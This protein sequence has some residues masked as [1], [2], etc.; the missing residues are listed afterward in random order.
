[1]IQ[2]VV[3][4]LWLTLFCNYSCSEYT[5]LLSLYQDK[6]CAMCEYPQ[7]KYYYINEIDKTCS[8]TCITKKQYS[9]FKYVF[10]GLKQ[11]NTTTLP[12]EKHGYHVDSATMEEGTCPLCST[13]DVYKKDYFSRIILKSDTQSTSNPCSI[14]YP[15]KN[16]QLSEFV[17]HTWYSQYQQEV[18]YQTIDSF[19]CV[20]ATYNI[21]K[22]RTV[23]FFHGNVI[24]VYNYANYNE[25]NGP[26]KNA[27]NATILCAKQVI[28]N[29]NSQ[30]SVAPCTVWSVFGGPYW[31]IGVGKN[32][33]WLIVSGGQPHVPYN[34]GCTTNVNQRNN[35]GLWIFSRN[36]MITKHHLKQAFSL[37]VHKGY[38]LSKMKEV[39]QTGCTYNGSFIK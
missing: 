9:T 39:K 34:D 38:T 35:A 16:I 13:F 6:C 26:A 28:Q 11:D 4:L 24:S 7:M 5:P 3:S 29:V 27:N 19:Y 32:Y 10:P 21:E 15:V 12:C 20:T 36:Q 17:K 31:I 14:V 30:F 23:P 22:N 1:M 33:E 37:L 8:E 2:R 25:V 18:S